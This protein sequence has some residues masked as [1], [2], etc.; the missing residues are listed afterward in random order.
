VIILL[1][2]VFLLLQN[3]TTM[4]QPIRKAI[5]IGSQ[6]PAAK[7]IPGV[8]K[9]LESFKRFLIAPSGGAWNEREIIIRTDPSLVEL[10]KLFSGFVADYL[11]IYFSGH[12]FTRLDGARMLCFQEGDFADQQLIEC[13]P[14][15][16][17]L[18]LVDACRTRERPGRIGAI[19]PEEKWDYATGYS[20]ARAIFDQYISDSAFGWTIVH[21]TE[22]DHPAIENE[23]GGYFTQAILDVMMTFQSSGQHAVV[24]IDHVVKEAALKL[25]KNTI[26]QNPCIYRSGYLSV[27]F[28]LVSPN[29]IYVNDNM[30][31]PAP[32]PQKNAGLVV[33]VFIGLLIYGLSK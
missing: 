11:L 21:A 13:N 5:L 2:P 7:K 12:G 8:Y 16:R 1:P 3:N 22:F 33:L 19:W 30:N 20:E 29:F 4:N 17:K 15:P 6:T 25:Q 18:M 23:N 32:V 27:P 10:E 24:G 26:P 14:S 31:L 9:D 28:G